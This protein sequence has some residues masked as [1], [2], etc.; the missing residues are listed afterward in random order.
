[1]PPCATASER[2]GPD[3]VFVGLG[4]PKQEIWM[5]SHCRELGAVLLGVGAAFDFHAGLVRRAPPLLQRAGLEWA[6]RIVQEP[7]RLWKRYATT[8]PCSSGD[9]SSRSAAST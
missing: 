4:A 9:C 2:R 7:G 6:H 1:M 8:L 5:Q 3:V